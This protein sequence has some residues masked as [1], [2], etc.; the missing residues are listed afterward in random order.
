MN[1]PYETDVAIER[2]RFDAVIFDMDGVV[3]D[4]AEGHAAA[5]KRTFDAVLQQHIG[6]DFEPFDIDRDYHAYVDGKPRHDGVKSFLDSRGLDLPLGS[7]EDPPDADTICGIGNRKNG[8]FQGWL[9]EKR[10]KTYPG[11][12][13]LVQELKDAG[14]AVAI[15]S[16]SK[17]CARV[18]ENAEL[19]D[20]FDARVDGNDLAA[21]TMPGKPAPDMLIEAARRVKATAK[22][23]VIVENSQAGVQAG[24]AGGFGLV[25]GV[26]RSS[27]RAGDGQAA[28]LKAHGADV[29]VRHVAALH[30]V[31]GGAED[32]PTTLID[33]LPGL[34]AAKAALEK[35]LA[36]R[37]PAVFL[38]YDGTLTP[39]VSDPKDAVLSPAMRETLHRLARVCPVAIVSGRDLA[40]LRELVGIDGIAYAGSHGFE[41]AAPPD[42]GGDREWGADYLGDLDRAEGAL[43]AQLA[44][45]RGVNVERKRFDVSV[46]YRNAPRWEVP[47]VCDAV[48]GVVGGNERLRLGR[49]KEVLQVQPNVDWHKGRALAWLLARG[50]LDTPA[51]LPLYIGDDLT[52]ENA[53]RAL[54][55]DGGAV[56][57][58]GLVIRDERSRRTAASY[59][60]EDPEAVRALLAWLA[61]HEE[62]AQR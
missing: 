53:F 11:A 62:R 23:T 13:H 49:G 50:G 10:V 41:V 20:A 43:K 36:E 34:E 58:I 17:N 5:W 19:L 15:F 42:M 35:V 32:H 28:A 24:K 30:V 14:I 51:T 31:T 37:R 40:Q 12:V 48:G 22:R 55:P 4:T 57:G 47:T 38:D 7:A 16:S 60:L 56:N 25:V 27:R 1:D 18:L 52:D 9:E 33:E 46:H 2:G 29:V 45:L 59:V 44:G 6:P 39:I 61:E 3:T 21:L 8:V 54:R 26:D